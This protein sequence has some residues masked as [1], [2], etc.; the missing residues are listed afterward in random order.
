MPRSTLSRWSVSRAGDFHHLEVR[1]RGAAVRAAPV[2]RD[3][4][5]AGA[6]RDAVFRPPLGLVVLEAALHADEQFVVVHFVTSII[7]RRLVVP[8]AARIVI[9]R[10]ISK[11]AFSRTAQSGQPQSSGRSSHR[12]PTGNPSRTAP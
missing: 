2:L 3:V 1:L 8:L 4:G 12:V 5:P 7:V 6:G 11:S 10:R 9:G